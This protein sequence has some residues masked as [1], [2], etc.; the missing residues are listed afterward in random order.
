M[1]H[2]VRAG[3]MCPVVT[4]LVKSSPGTSG[5]TGMLILPLLKT[6]GVATRCYRKRPVRM[7][8]IKRS[9]VKEMKQSPAPLRPCYK[10]IVKE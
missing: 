2:V 9:F 5:A 8:E 10:I 6:V 7:N 1:L 3:T 4:T